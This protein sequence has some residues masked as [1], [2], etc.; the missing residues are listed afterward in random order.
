MDIIKDKFDLV[1]YQI[2][3]NSNV[4]DSWL[5]KISQDILSHTNF[6][7]TLIACDRDLCQATAK[8]IITY[9]LATCSYESFPKY[10]RNRNLIAQ[11]VKQLITGEL[12]FSSRNSLSPQ[13]TACLNRIKTF[14]NNESIL[15]KIEVFVFYISIEFSLDRFKEIIESM[16]IELGVS[17]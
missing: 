11:S 9:A 15:K 3:H 14:S 16:F 7:K 13:L 5:D 2:K 6:Q 1:V 4:S 8:L 12:Q 17:K 10:M